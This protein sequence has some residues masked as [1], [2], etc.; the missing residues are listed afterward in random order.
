VIETPLGVTKLAM[1]LLY[2]TEILRLATSIPHIGRLDQPDGTAERRSPTCG[3]SI[4]VDVI[5]DQHG[6]ISDFAQTVSACALGQASAALMGGHAMGRSFTEL[7]D[8]KN[9]LAAYLAG[10]QTDPGTWPGLAIFQ[11]AVPYTARHAAILL[12]FEAIKEAAER[13]K[14]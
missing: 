5:L 10:A 14:T 1:S 11:N 7:T 8:V 3:S 2:T 4:I 12:P 9:A 6:R 13:A